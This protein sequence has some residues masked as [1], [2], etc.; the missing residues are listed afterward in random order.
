M[1]LFVQGSRLKLKANPAKPRIAIVKKTAVVIETVFDTSQNMLLLID[2]SALMFIKEQMKNSR[3]ES[4][5]SLIKVFMTL[6]DVV[7]NFT[8]VRPF[9]TNAYLGLYSDTLSIA[10]DTTQT[11]SVSPISTNITER[12]INT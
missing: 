4:N 11:I 9:G 7:D 8:F 5:S 2:V 10:L 12:L 6:S 3:Q 1:S